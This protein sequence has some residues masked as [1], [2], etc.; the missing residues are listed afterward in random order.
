[1]KNKTKKILIFFRASYGDFYL[2]F[3]LFERFRNFKYK[4]DELT[5]VTSHVVLD[6]LYLKN[7]FDKL[8]PIDQFIPTRDYD[9]VID[10]DINVTGVSAT[11]KSNM[12][13]FDILES[14]Y[15]V[16]LNRKN[17]YDIFKLNVKDSEKEKIDNE[18]D[19]NSVIIHTTNINKKPYGKAPDQN[20][21]AELVSNNRN[22]IFYQV[23]S[24]YRASKRIQPDYT[25]DY[26]NTNIIDIRDK[27][28]FR[29]LSYILEKTKTFIAVD[30][31][32][33]HLSLSSKKSGIVIWGSSSEKIHG[34]DHNVNLNS[35][36]PC[37][38]CIDLASNLNCCLYKNS[39]L[40]PSIKNLTSHLNL[41]Q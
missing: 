22:I 41:L 12:T 6:M 3:P 31:I 14:T 37:S 16:E 17:F 35:N 40:F 30:S 28:N 34:H 4:H 39:S 29:E 24:K 27:Y 26:D 18:I 8:I 5:L 9:K 1:M 19:F 23:G 13:F 20:W 7:W 15:D 11:H 36:R 2:N 25:F 32:I 21:W 10:L 38:P 33:S